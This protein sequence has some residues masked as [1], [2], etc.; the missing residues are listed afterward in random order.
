MLSWAQ[1]DSRLKHPPVDSCETDESQD[2]TVVRLQS[3]RT[4]ELFVTPMLASVLELC[5]QDIA[6]VVNPN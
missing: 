2:I 6:S 3:K 5:L 1:H 4:S